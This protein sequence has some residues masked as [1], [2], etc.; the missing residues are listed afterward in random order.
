MKWQS[1]KLKEVGEVVTGNTPP[2]TQREY[3]GT[4]YKFIKPTDMREGQRYVP[5]TEEYY[6]ELAYQKYR[7]SLLPVNTPCV[8]TIG[9][10]GKK[11]CLTDEPSFTNQAVNA[12]IP[13]ENFDGEFLYYCL[14][15]RLPYVKQLDSGTTSGRENVSKSSFSNIVIEAP[16][17]AIQKRI[18]SI[19]SAYDN[20]IE[21]NNK[22]IK[23][24]EQMAENLYKE[25]FVRFRF[26]GHE[27]TRFVP[28]NMGK[29]PSTFT[30]A[31]MQDVF[32]YY[33]G[34]GWGEDEYSS[35]FPV[36]AKVIRGADFPFVERGDLGTCPNRFHKESNYKARKLEPGDIILEVSGGT[37]E[38]PVGR[39]ILVSQQMLDRF[40]GQV[41]CA[42]F[43]KLVRL[44]K[45]TISPIYFYYWM[46]FLYE[47]RIIDRFQLQSTGIIN[48]KFEYFLKK[49]DVMLPPS[50]IMKKFEDLVSPIHAQIEK[51]AMETEN[52]IKQRDLL[53]PRL[54]SG[55]LA[56]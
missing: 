2:T 46:Q 51:L 11:M 38:Q 33:I 9:S 37:A 10:L 19:L 1:Y 31:K 30:L 44:K 26:P 56:V 40:N 13:N 55:K 28:S 52:L 50:E 48:F 6:S 25:W 17:L 53:L 41:I 39:T 7:K 45:E 24:L 15:T 3:Y 43:C 14:R 36:E 23:I 20:L 47:T 18:A 8:V 54:M 49:G 35:D 12:V 4:Q 42:S 16:S 29:I 32:E 34:G 27:T 22:R 21:N 5:I